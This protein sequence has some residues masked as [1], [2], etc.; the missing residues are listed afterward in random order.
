M[1]DVERRA[2][3]S[4][5]LF[6]F[7][8]P[9]RYAG[10]DTYW[11]KTG[12]FREAMKRLLPEGWTVSD[13]PGVW[14]QT[15]PPKD[16][17][18]DSGFKIHLSTAH[19]NA[20][21]MLEAV[22][23]VLVE[24][25][26][27]FKVLVDEQILDISNSHL[28][29]RESCGKFI[30]IYPADVAQLKRLMA[31]LH[32][33][34][35]GLDG[36]YILSDKRYEGSKILFYRYGAFRGAERLNV[37][38]ELED[39]LFTDDGRLLSDNRLPY[40][41]LPEGVPDPFP[42]TEKEDAEIILK[43]RYKAVAPL[44]S[45]SSKGG[46][47]KCIDLETS[48]EVV[49]KEGRP[50]INRG[51]WSPHDCV[52]TLRNEHRILTLLEHTGVAPRPIDFFQEWEHC[53][54]I[55]QM[56][57]GEPL[58]QFLATGQFSI[59]LVTD[60][61]ADDVRRF[62]ETFASFA[63]KVVAGLRI[64]HEQ[65]VVVQDISPHNI[66]LDQR[67]EK[68]MFIDFEAAYTER[69]GVESPV[70][71][72]RTP[73]FGVEAE[74]GKKPTVL[75][76]YKALSSLLGECL[77]PTTTFFSLAPQNRPMLAHV[78]RE[79]GVPDAF[80]RLIFGVGEEPE[81]ADELI[82]DAERSIEGITAPR[83]LPPIRSDNDL[84]RIVGA[85]RS[86]IVEQ[87]QSGGDPLELP[88]DYRRFYT[89]RLSVAYGAS[90]IALFLKRAT[91]EVPGVFQDALAR[92][93]AVIKNEAFPPG[94]YMGAAGVAWTLLELGMRKEAEALMDTASQSPL[95]FD[96]ADLFFGAAGWGLTNLFFFERL[97]DE[98]YLK[99]AVDAFLGIIPKLTREGEGYFYTNAGDVYCGLAHGASGIGYFLLRLYQ[100]TLK[101]EHLDV[102]ARLFD[103]DLSKAEERDGEMVF[104]RSKQDPTLYPYWRIGNTGIG[105]VALR[106]H[107]A[108]G[109]P[110]YMD[111][112]RN[113]AHH[114]KGS[115]SVFPTNFFGMAGFGNFFVDMYQH[116]R[117]EAHLEEARRFVDRV[118]LFAIEKPSGIVFPGEE[119]LRVSTDYGTGSAGTGMFIH[120][121][122]A[123]G[124]L[125]YFDF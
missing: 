45:F 56:V 72:I 88:V 59:I 44:S 16:Q 46:I 70:V 49:A 30:T 47:Y 121:I 31:R 11:S 68:L 116:T 78:A 33:I 82:A 5:Y 2:G 61:S 101:G 8:H 25:G 125:P 73:G 40:F 91:G 96:N 76:D 1:E 20:I 111:I 95:L 60:P 83:P 105:C 7:V 102:A 42:D 58:A 123:G 57:K 14:C 26:V 52:A 124:G 79:K 4:I 97:R 112:A 21:E 3:E 13:E 12:D 117:E 87:I 86:Y 114:L 75:E 65:G 17:T 41:F 64:I 28:W 118:M 92:E 6:T 110:R 63:R 51:R 122:L 77:Y 119:L 10:I 108:L 106:F 104:H 94:L 29:G 53:F 37:Y 48:T 93:A 80:V 100:A 55:M 27:A 74:E 84:R 18:P 103:F 24:E 66:L 36:P 69:D 15:R 23:P 54:L 98:K 115:Y 71:P 90:G 38:G 9:D 62:C 107:A 39:L 34:T 19:E 22:V 113:V 99:N 67:M 89:N 120:R 43:G 81:R 35:K 109:D 85:I 50:F 32:E